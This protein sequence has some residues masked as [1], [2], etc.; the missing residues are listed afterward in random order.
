MKI[1][2][3]SA[4]WWHAWQ[5]LIVNSLNSVD[6][7]RPRRSTVSTNAGALPTPL[8][9]AAVLSTEDVRRDVEEL[10]WRA[11]PVGS[12]L[13]IRAGASASPVPLAAIPAA[14]LMPPPAAPGVTAKRKRGPTGTGKAAI[15]RRERRMADLLTLPSVEDLS[16]E[17]QGEGGVASAM[18]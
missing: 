3:D 12:V 16:A 1:T 7:L 15:K 13:S 18:V 10:G 4:P 14:A 9:A 2:K 11:C 5:S 6:L 8:A 17:W